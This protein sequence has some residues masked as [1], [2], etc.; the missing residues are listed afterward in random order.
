MTAY[1]R[2]IRFFLIPKRCEGEYDPSEIHNHGRLRDHLVGVAVHMGW[3][4]VGFFV[5]LYW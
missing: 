4:M 1:I 3:Q 2:T 5:F